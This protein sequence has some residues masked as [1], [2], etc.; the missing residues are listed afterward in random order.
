MAGIGVNFPEYARPGIILG[1]FY[2]KTF[3]KIGLFPDI[4]INTY[5]KL[6]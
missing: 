2:P 5:R 4:V 3:E 1:I 6:N